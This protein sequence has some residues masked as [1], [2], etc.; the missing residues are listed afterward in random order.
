MADV[1][2]QNA[3][4]RFN[5]VAAVSDLSLTIADGEF[6]VLLGPTG[7]GKT[8]TLRL[9]TGLERLDAG[10]ASELDTSQQESVV[11]SLRAN[12]P[13]LEQTLQQ[14]KNA[15]ALL[16]GIPPERVK[17]RG[18]SLRS[19]TIP[20][21][22]PGMPAELITQR[23]DI[24]FAEAQLAAADADVANARAQLLPSITLTGTGAEL[25]AD[26][27]VRSAYLGL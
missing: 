12:I 25:L 13:P 8:T 10:T 24:R 1:V 14:N 21:V 22:T 9:I 18:G 3:T 6:L 16:M 11:N 27:R 20:R 4:K 15:L 7:A 5:E 19:V 26:D 17:I 2:L 23:P